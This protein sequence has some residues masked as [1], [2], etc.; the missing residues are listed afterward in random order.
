MTSAG[1]DIVSISRIEESIDRF[2][3]RFLHRIFTEREVAYCR[4]RRGRA[5]GESSAARFAAK[6]A[7]IKALKGGAMA[8]W[9]DIELDSIDEGQLQ[10]LLHGG[11]A[12]RAREL[13]LTHI[14]VS[15]S[16]EGEYA[17]AV[18]IA[19]L[20]GRPKDRDIEAIDVSSPGACRIPLLDEAEAFSKVHLVLDGGSSVRARNLILVVA[21][22]PAAWQI[23][24][25]ALHM[26]A[27]LRNLDRPIVSLL[28]LYPSFLNDIS[29]FISPT[30]APA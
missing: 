6:E 15:V 23:T 14:N 30:P 8:N 12:I 2:G 28:C 4:A 22:S 26:Y 21:K 10:V 1:T 9:R 19:D 7:V 3:D 27:T 29:N 13:G 5:Q 18:A 25:R 24:I 16:H 20:D 17:I 11:A